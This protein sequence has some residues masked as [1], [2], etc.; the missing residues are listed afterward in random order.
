MK[1]QDTKTFCRLVIIRY[2]CIMLAIAIVLFILWVID[3]IP[4]GS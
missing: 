4:N 2:A 3:L 1:L